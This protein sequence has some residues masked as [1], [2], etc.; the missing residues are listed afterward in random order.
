MI[1]GLNKIDPFFANNIHQTV[2]LRN[3]ARPDACAQIFER[4]RLADTLKRVAHNGLDQ[5]EDAQ[6]GT[7]VGS[8]Q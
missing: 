2:F 3:P 1:S 4:L 7:P 6:S 5:I 8:T